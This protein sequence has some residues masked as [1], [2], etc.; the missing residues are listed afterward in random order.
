MSH[1]TKCCSL[2]LSESPSLCGR[3]V[4]NITLVGR[5]HSL[6]LISST[7]NLICRDCFSPIPS[8]A[9]DVT[10]PLGTSQPSGHGASSI[11]LLKDGIAS[12]CTD[13]EALANNCRGQEKEQSY[14]ESP[15]ERKEGRTQIFQSQSLAGVLFQIRAFDATGIDGLIPLRLRC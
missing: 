8:R 5:L 12:G 15:N 6:Q 10:E 11:S 14:H 3:F 4:E 13:S 9:L 2:H 1:G 7:Q